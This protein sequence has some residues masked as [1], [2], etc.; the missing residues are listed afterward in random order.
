MTPAEVRFLAAARS[1]VL[2]TIDPE[3]RPRQVPVCFVV[4]GEPATPVIW[5]PIDDKPK[6]VDDPHRLARVRD[7]VDRPTVS[8]LVDRWDE[9]WTRLGWLRVL[10]Q[11]WLVEAGPV[12]TMSERIP[13]LAALRAKY[14][15]YVD[16]DLETR[17]LIRIL[18]TTATSW[19]DLAIRDP[20]TG[21]R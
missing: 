5:T 17:P 10:G 14:P 6:R 21:P 18:P 1:A 2:A 11:A 16:H 12:D 20:A 9:D 19:G 8:L 4:D 7:L 13:V 15:R 3:G